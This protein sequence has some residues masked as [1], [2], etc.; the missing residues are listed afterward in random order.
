MT[1]YFYNLQND[2]YGQP[3]FRASNEGGQGY[4]ATTDADDFS[5][6]A[7]RFAQWLNENGYVLSGGY[8]VINGRK[9]E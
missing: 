6:A 4:I 2:E 3:I 5:Q 8:S 9:N 1:W 7:L